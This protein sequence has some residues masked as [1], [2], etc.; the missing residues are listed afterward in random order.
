MQARAGRT[1]VGTHAM[2]AAAGGKREIGV[3]GMPVS[4][5]WKEGN[6]MSGHWVREL[7]A[8][9]AEEEMAMLRQEMR[10]VEEASGECPDG[11][12]SCDGWH[13]SSA[14]PFGNVSVVRLS[15]ALLT[16][17]ECRCTERANWLSK[18]MGS[19]SPRGLGRGATSRYCSY[20]EGAL[21]FRQCEDAR[22]KQELASKHAFGLEAA[23]PWF[24]EGAGSGSMK[25]RGV[26]ADRRA[27]V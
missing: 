9:S 7:R 17:R 4:G 21:R 14:K 8:S 16:G 15:P 12:V 23:R 10:G 18:G 5:R 25:E 2:G 13:R 6:A 19:A 26:K 3:F 24:E 11:S 27:S 22:P 1:R 20:G